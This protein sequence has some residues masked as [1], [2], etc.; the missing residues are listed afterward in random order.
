[1]AYRAHHDR[2]LFMSMI[3]LVTP[4]AITLAPSGHTVD[5]FW[6]YDGTIFLVKGPG[7]GSVLPKIGSA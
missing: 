5:W 1:M 6:N 4:D 7:P 2:G 3:V